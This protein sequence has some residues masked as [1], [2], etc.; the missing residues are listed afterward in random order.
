MKLTEEGFRREPITL[1]EDQWFY[2]GPKGLTIAVTLRGTL[3]SI[4]G[5]VEIPWSKL[6][7]PIERKHAYEKRKARK[8]KARV[9][10]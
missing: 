7:G 3:Q 9:R 4:A 5:I 10:K 1:T 6:K 8:A 2:E